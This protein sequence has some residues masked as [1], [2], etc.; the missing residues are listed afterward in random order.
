MGTKTRLRALI[1]TDHTKHSAE[2]SLYA[3]AAEMARNPSIESIKIATRGNVKNLDFFDSENGAKI[4]ATE[5]GSYFKFSTENHQLDTND[6]IIDINDIDFVW[7]RLPP[8]IDKKLLDYISDTF[9]NQQIINDP[10]GIYTT[11]SKEYLLNFQSVCPPM[12][13]CISK[14]DIIAF[15]KQFPIVL[16]PLREYG[17]RGIV[18]IDGD[19]VHNGSR[20]ESLHDFLDKLPNRDFSYLG[21]K[22]L[23][24]VKQGDKR[25]IVINGNIMGASL[26]LPM[27]GS[28]VCNVAQGGTSHHTK[29]T[30]EE[31]KIVETINQDLITKGIVMYGIDTLVNDK[32]FRVLSEINTTS[33]GGLPQIATLTN[34]PLVQKGVEYLIEYLLESKNRMNA[35]S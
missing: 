32:G 2:N 6:H 18:K 35:I 13:L 19:I 3:L 21:V 20:E 4:Y 31:I 5:I 34:T 16:K 33:I 11:G 24:N 30:K 12:K 25:I 1:L 9:K 22:Y 29:V 27:E 23:K 28:W 15:S 8:P 14:M 17:G 7:L 10:K 26:R